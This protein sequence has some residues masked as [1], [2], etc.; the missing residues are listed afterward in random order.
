MII[1]RI[2]RITCASLV[3]ALSVCLSFNAFADEAS[4]SVKRHVELEGQSNFRDIGGYKTASGNAV[5]RGLIFRSGQLPHLTDQ[6]VQ[7]LKDLNI[8]TVFNFLTE[9]EITAAGKDRLPEG[10]LTVPLPIDTDGGLAGEILEARQK[11]DFS[12]VPPDLNPQI[13]RMLVN[14]GKKEYSELL[15]KI[16][17]ADEPIVFHC[18]H[19][20]HRTG[21]ATAILLWGLGVPWETV[22][23]DYLLSNKYR[24]DEVDKRLKQFRDMAAKNRKIPAE[25]VDM[26][27]FQAFYILQ[28]NYIDAVRDEIKE[29]HGSI[30][31]YMIDGLGLTDQ[32]MRKLRKRLLRD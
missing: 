16:A 24:K 7:Q 27:N 6:D 9:T 30:R 18:S 5:K 32:D 26:T 3:A 8:T 11:A 10:T 14:Q 1:H 12:K 31:G 17:E 19:G 28:G 21:T 23:E 4:S 29:K 20:V 13:H 2:A 15:K 25:Q 22:R